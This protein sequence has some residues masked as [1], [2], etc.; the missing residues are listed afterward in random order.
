MPLPDEFDRLPRR[1]LDGQIGFLYRDAADTADQVAA[2]EQ[3]PELPG[4]PLGYLVQALRCNR[5]IGEL[6][7]VARVQCR[8]VGF[9]DGARRGQSEADPGNAASA[10]SSGWG[11]LSDGPAKRAGRTCPLMPTQGHRST[12]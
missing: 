9:R 4:R 7:E 2:V 10:A 12:S 1:H 11:V 5:E 3:E 6:S 8:L